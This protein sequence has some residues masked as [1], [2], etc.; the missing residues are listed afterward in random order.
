[1]R[2]ALA[3]VVAISVSAAPAPAWAEDAKTAA[4]AEAQQTPSTFPP[5]TKEKCD[6]PNALGVE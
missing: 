5:L 6:N 4:P 2:I 3:L 1:M